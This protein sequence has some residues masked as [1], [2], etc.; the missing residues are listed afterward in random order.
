MAL[1]RII[2][3]LFVMVLLG[4]TLATAGDFVYWKIPSPQHGQT[5]SYGSENRRAW[6]QRGNHLGLFIEFTN[7]PYVDRVTPR[8][9]D[10]FSFHF[11]NVTLGKDGRTF[12]Y[13]PPQQKAV[14]VA[15]KHPGLFGDD[16]RL[17][18]SASLVVDQ[19]HGWLTLTLLVR[20]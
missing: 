10:D 12:Y 7:D 15:M 16:I 4:P 19:P 11:P 6:L 8:Q 18:P 3:S 5:F 2:L 14:P 9:Y 17:L 13:H 20:K 1:R